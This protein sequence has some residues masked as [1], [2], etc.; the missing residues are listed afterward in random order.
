MPLALALPLIIAGW[1]SSKADPSHVDQR[2]Y[3]AG[4][5]SVGPGLVKEGMPATSAC[6]QGLEAAYLFMSDDFPKYDT[7]SFKG[8]EGWLFGRTMS[9]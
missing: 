7:M 5:H 2:S 6:E 4:Y 9:V 8:L 1:G 3:E